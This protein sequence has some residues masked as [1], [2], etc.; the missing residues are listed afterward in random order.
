MLIDLCERG[1]IP[2]VIAR[3]GMRRLMAERLALESAD[4]G[5][6]EAGQFRRRL[7]ELRASP[8]AI[9]TD[10]ANE[11]HYEVPAA[12]FRQVLGTHLKYSC[13][14]YGDGIR[15]L[16]AAEAAMLRLSCERAE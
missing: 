10:K 6:A 12:F 16:D 14:W 11:Q 3:A 13:C 8:V 7:R 2:D 4:R 1:L 5:L 15:D 9:E